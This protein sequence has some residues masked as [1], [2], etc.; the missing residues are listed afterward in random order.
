[1]SRPPPEIFAALSGGQSRDIGPK[2]V[3]PWTVHARPAAV[4]P[5]HV[6]VSPTLFMQSGVLQLQRGHGASIAVERC[7]RESRYVKVSVEPSE[8]LSVPVIGRGKKVA[9][10][11]G[12]PPEESG[13]GGPRKPP[14][15]PLSGAQSA[16]DVQIVRG[17]SSQR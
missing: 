6:P 13:S 12:T 7:T 2:I 1:M 9:T 4:P 15:R 3:V 5:L 14:H 16:S 17:F 8:T 10:H 11:T